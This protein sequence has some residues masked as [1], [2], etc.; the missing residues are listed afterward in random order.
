MVKKISALLLA[1]IMCFG[2]AIGLAACAGSEP[3]GYDSDIAYSGDE[4][5]EDEYYESDYYEEDANNAGYYNE[6][7]GAGGLYASESTGSY[8]SGSS[9]QGSNYTEYY[10]RSSKYLNQHYEK[11][12]ID[13][14]FASCEE[15]EQAASDV[16]NNPNALYKT[17]KEDGDGIYYIEATNEFVVL[18]TDGYIR[19]YFLPDSGKKYFDKQ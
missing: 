14:G 19:T 13:M 4:S 18:S 9:G 7:S 17:E 12:G 15:Y 11:H 8:S 5:C 3:S 10:F 6:G 1:L 2:I 16:I